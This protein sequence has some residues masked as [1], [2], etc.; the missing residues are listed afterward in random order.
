MKGTPTVV[1][2]FHLLGII[3]WAAAVYL[4]A[5]AFS[6]DTGVPTGLGG[7][8][9]ANMQLMHFQLVGFVVSMGAMIAG[10]LFVI[11]AAIIDQ[12]RTRS[13]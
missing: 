3:L 5:Q 9:V 11:G 10:T 13:V 7:G 4:F 2:V 6:M 8:T 12:L 1:Y